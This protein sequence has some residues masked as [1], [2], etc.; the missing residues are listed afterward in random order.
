[1]KKI[2][3]V[4][5]TGVVLAATAWCLSVY[6]KPMP[7][8]FEP[9]T[10]ES[11]DSTSSDVLTPANYISVTSGA[12]QKVLG[13][14]NESIGQ[15]YVDDTACDNISIQ[16]QEGEYATTM[17]VL[18]SEKGILTIETH[19]EGY[20]PDQPY[21]TASTT[22]TS[23]DMV[24]GDVIGIAELFPKAFYA[25]GDKLNRSVVNTIADI[26]AQ[27]V[28]LD[29]I[30]PE[31]AVEYRRVASGIDDGSGLF[32]QDFEF[33]DFAIVRDTVLVYREF[34]HALQACETVINIPIS[35][36]RELAGLGSI[37]ERMLVVR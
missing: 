36:L 17:R 28:Q 27:Y 10:Y 14:I 2:S 20:C 35:H 29:D 30:D 15:S 9:I 18:Y 11:I 3:I 32:F 25:S 24:S 33:S 26:A 7:R 8:E 4:I 1:M 6:E 23:Y 21:P 5:V 22:Y 12:S 13:I 16:L 19:I 37:L 34:P 31:C